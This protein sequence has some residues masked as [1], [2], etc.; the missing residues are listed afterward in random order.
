MLKKEYL[1]AYK[2]S[3]RKLAAAIDVSPNRITGI[4]NGDRSVTADTAIR[5]GRF[6]HTSSEFWMNLQTAH[7][8]SIAEGKSD[9]GDPVLRSHGRD[10]S[11]IDR[12]IAFCRELRAKADPQRGKAA[13]KDFIDSLYEEV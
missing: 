4:I 5:L 1:A 10:S 13:D 7:D 9:P 12:S 3:A 2:M 6:F 8:L 11:L